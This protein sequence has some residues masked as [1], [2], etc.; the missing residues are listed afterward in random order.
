MRKGGAVYKKGE[1]GT[2]SEVEKGG[3][4]VDTSLSVLDSFG[5]K[6]GWK[7]KNP[8]KQTGRRMFTQCAV[9]C[10]RDQAD[11]ISVIY[12]DDKP[13]LSADVAPQLRPVMTADYTAS[14][15]HL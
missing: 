14:N 10:V 2:L 5:Q 12:R 9:M 6:P 13:C 4:Q 7:T 8:A 11:Q 1:S 15:I 3:R